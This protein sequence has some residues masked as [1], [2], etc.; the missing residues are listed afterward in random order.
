MG[1]GVELLA[2]GTIGYSAS[3]LHKA[4]KA[5]KREAEAQNKLIAEE[6][7]KAL[8]ERK[9]IIDDQRQQLVTGNELKAGSGSSAGITGLKGQIKQETLG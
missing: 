9:N 2:L 8:Q 4:N 1:T 6:K 7:E 3:E 5:A